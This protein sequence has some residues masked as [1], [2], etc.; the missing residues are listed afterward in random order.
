M[1]FRLA[2]AL[3][4]ALLLAGCLTSQRSMMNLGPEEWKAQVALRGVDP[5]SVPDPL[6]ITPE[7]REVTRRLAGMGTD[8]EKMTRLQEALFD[9]KRFPFA[10]DNRG[11]F[12]AAEAF[13]RREGNCLSFTNLFVA[14]ARSL[15]ITVTTA[16]VLRAR[17]SEQ[18]GDLIVVNTHVIAVMPYGEERVYFD[19]DRTR[20]DRPAVVMPLDDM[21]VTALYLNNRGAEDLRSGHPETAITKFEKAVKL[22]PEIAAAWA[23]LGVARRR[24]GDGPGAM[25]A[26][27]RALS[28]DPGNPTT[29]ANLAAFYRSQGKVQE[30]REALVAADL[31]KASAHMLLVRGDLELSQGNTAEAVKLYR[32]ARHAAPTLPAPLLGLARAELLRSRPAKAERYLKE[33]LEIDPGSVE[34]Q[35]LLARLQE[36]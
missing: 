22:A 28:I 17:A 20:R 11:T 1:R 31:S 14:M 27:A 7:M 4:P 8:L 32:R 35:G 29:L 30:A 6:L 16:L 26:Y 23:N 3:I 33:A 13:F 10:Y 18:D 24:M 15:N 2:A 19:F 25:K 36:R 5:A 21:Q 34:A 9:Q 12:T